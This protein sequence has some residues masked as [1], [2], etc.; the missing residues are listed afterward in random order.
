MK[1][2]FYGKIPEAGDFISRH[3]PRGFIDFW[4]QWLQAALESSR[5]RLGDEW[6]Q[7]YLVSPMWRFALSPGICTEHAWVGVLMPSVDKVGR[8][9]PMTIAVPLPP[10]SVLLLQCTVQTEWYEKAE[11]L[12]IDMLSTDNFNVDEFTDDVAM[13][14][15]PE[16]SAESFCLDGNV[17]AFDNTRYPLENIDGLQSLFTTMLAKHIQE[18]YSEYSIWWTCGSQDVKSSLMISE[19]MAPSGGYSDMITGKWDADIWQD[20]SLPKCVKD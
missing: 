17:N 18:Q 19:G 9:F 7:Y 2:G 8:Y 1:P 11:K 5:T 13:L 15:V 14:G 3:L 6:L 16:P 12:L 10:E 20:A 4:D